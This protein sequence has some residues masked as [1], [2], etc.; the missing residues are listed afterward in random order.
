ML[1]KWKTESKKN[2]GN[3]KIFDVEIVRRTNPQDGK[4]SEFTVLNSENWVNIIVITKSNE[5]VL[6]NQYRHGTN[7]IELEIPGGLIETDET[8]GQASIR[9]CKEETGYVSDSPVEFLGEIFPNPAFLDNRCYTFLWENC[10]QKLEQNLDD[11][12][13]IDIIKYPI[14]D[15]KNLILK[16]EIRHGVIIAAFNLLMLRK[17]NLWEK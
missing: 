16:G 10:E 5:I 17:R 2:L 15:I 3:H 6:V 12:E 4:T 14:E 13:D 9:E 11:F 1:K 8:P 7:T